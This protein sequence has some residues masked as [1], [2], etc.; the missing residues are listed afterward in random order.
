MKIGRTIFFEDLTKK[1]K[2]SQEATHHLRIFASTQPIKELFSLEVYIMNGIIVH[3][4][5]TKSDEKAQWKIKSLFRSIHIPKKWNNILGAGSGRGDTSP[6]D[7]KLLWI[8][9]FQIFPLLSWKN[10]KPLWKIARKNEASQP[11]CLSHLAPLFR[12][13]EPCVAHLLGPPTHWNQPSHS[14]LVA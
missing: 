5:E 14:K 8:F 12:S 10:A 2:Q 7:P 11:S 6:N 3:Q 13:S 9:C 4:P 1:K